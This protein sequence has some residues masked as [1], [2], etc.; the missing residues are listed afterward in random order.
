MIVISLP[1]LRLPR[2]PWPW[3]LFLVL[4][5]A[6]QIW[7]VNPVHTDIS[8]RLYIEITAL[9]VLVA[10]NCRTDVVCWGI[11]AGGAGVLALSLYAAPRAA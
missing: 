7:T 10:A 2:V 11:G 1:W 5:L 8:N 3:L 4:C 9:A 6:S